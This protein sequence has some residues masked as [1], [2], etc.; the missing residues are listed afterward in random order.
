M[1]PKRSAPST[2]PG[3]APHAGPGP[4]RV[5][6]ANASP[7]SGPASHLEVLDLIEQEIQ[8]LRIDF[9]RFLSGALPFPPE[10]QRTRIQNQLKGLR[11]ATMRS[12][13]EGFRLGVLEARFNSYNELF[14]R[15]VREREEGRRVARVAAAP[16]A[17][18]FDPRRGIVVDG[19]VDRQAAE[20]LYT[21]LAAGSGGGPNFDL[22]TFQTYLERQTA[23]L[24]GKTGCAAVQFRL[25]E[26]DGKLKLK[27]RPV[28]D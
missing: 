5:R 26:E 24:R 27:A 17:P 11:N 21:A 20:A 3:V 1:N 28:G 16:S 14:N 18:Q 6:G 7:K 15:R 13:V 8:Q 4:E 22:A 10:E 23:A 25:A 19:K 12:A 2:G 9:E